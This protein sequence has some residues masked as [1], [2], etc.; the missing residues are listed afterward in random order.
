MGYT[1]KSN[2]CNEDCYTGLEEFF[3][4][5]FSGKCLKIILKFVRAQFSLFAV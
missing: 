2:K 5:F 1:I 4:V 3:R